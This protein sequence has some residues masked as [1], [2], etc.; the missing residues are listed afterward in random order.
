MSPDVEGPD[1]ESVNSLTR[2][3][4]AIAWPFGYD[5]DGD[6]SEDAKV[7][8][9]SRPDAAHDKDA[10]RYGECAGEFGRE[11]RC[12][13]TVEAGDR[14]GV[15]RRADAVAGT[16]PASPPLVSERHLDVVAE[17][18]DIGEAAVVEGLNLFR[19]DAV[20]AGLGPVRVVLDDEILSP[21]RHGASSRQIAEARDDQATAAHEDATYLAKRLARV[22]PPPTLPGTHDVECGVGQSRLFSACGDE[23]DGQTLDSGGATRDLQQIGRYVESGGVH[24]ATSEPQGERSGSSAQIQDSL[25]RTDPMLLLQSVEERR[26][27]AGAML[28]VVSDGATEVDRPSPMTG[29]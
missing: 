11:H 10:V 25:P 13:V 28:F 15:Q 22:E 9:G 8:S 16:D 24:V 29:R 19:M 6:E 27:E 17:T 7:T 1:A 2:P 23:S 14:I 18:L 20:P 21:C 12:E 4:T 5:V 26:R 3:V